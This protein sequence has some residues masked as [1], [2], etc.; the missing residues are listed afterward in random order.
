MSRDVR[1]G[2]KILKVP[3]FNSAILET[4]IDFERKYPFHTPLA[5]LMLPTFKTIILAIMWQIFI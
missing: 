2:N 1:M 3:V 5:A 4:V